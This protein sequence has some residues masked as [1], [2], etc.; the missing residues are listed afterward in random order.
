[1]TT[2]NVARSRTFHVRPLRGT[3]P[4]PR[5]QQHLQHSAPQRRRPP[6]EDTAAT[7]TPRT[8]RPRN[9]HPRRHRQPANRQ[10]PTR[11]RVRPRRRAVAQLRHRPIRLVALRRHPRPTRHDREQTART[12][13]R[14]H[15][16]QPLTQAG[17]K[18]APPHNP[19]PPAGIL[20]TV[21]TPVTDN[22]AH[23]ADTPELDQPYAELGLADDEYA[24]IREILAR[25]PTET[26]LAMYSV[27]WSE[28]CSYK[29]SKRHLS[30]FGETTTDEMR[31]NMLVGIGENAGVID[32]G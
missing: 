14:P 23:A 19:T 17:K 2:R 4:L 22:T 28:H 16:R 6:T 13:P 8:R 20:W 21:E 24:R 15:R 27:M 32:I 9:R 1:R 11:V 31:A 10:H 25:R 30:Y 5:R 3:R 26:E 29:S 12:T 7:T 18:P